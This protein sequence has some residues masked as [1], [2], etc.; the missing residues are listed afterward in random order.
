VTASAVRGLT[1]DELRAEI[2]ANR[3]VIAWVIA[4]LGV[5]TAVEYT[6]ASN[7]HTTLVARYEHTVIVVGYGDNTVTVLDGSLTYSRSQTQFLAS[8]GVLGNMA[9]VGR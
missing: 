4:D 5:G 2:D 1:W 6:A 3:P 7:G 8:W 9:V